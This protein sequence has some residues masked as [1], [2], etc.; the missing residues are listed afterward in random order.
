MER[1]V[2]S[3]QKQSAATKGKPS[4]RV[5]TDQLAASMSAGRKGKSG[6]LKRYGVTNEE[7]EAQLGNGNKWCVFRKHFALASEFKAKTSACNACHSEYLRANNLQIKFG[8]TTEWYEAKL[9]E[10]G[11]GCAVC[12]SKSPQSS[13]YRFFAIDHDHKTGYT[14]GLLCSRC[15]T[16]M[17][18]IDSYPGWCDSAMSYINYYAGKADLPRGN[19]NTTRPYKRRRD[20]IGKFVPSPHEMPPTVLNSQQEKETC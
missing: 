15:N 17:E 14:R 3:R 4:G 18:R 9:A 2:E 6:K 8:V 12:K 20:P 11:G 10:Q 1:S 5:W 19:G 7:Y 13:G 16:S